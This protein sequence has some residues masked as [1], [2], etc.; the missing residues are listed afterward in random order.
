MDVSVIF[1]NLNFIGMKAS[2]STHDNEFKINSNFAIFL[3]NDLYQVS[4]F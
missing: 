4:M 2:L 1:I 3:K